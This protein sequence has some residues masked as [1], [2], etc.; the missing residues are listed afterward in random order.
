MFTIDLGP[1]AG[2]TWLVAREVAINVWMFVRKAGTVILAF[3]DSSVGRPDISGCHRTRVVSITELVLHDAQLS[4]E[5]TP[6]DRQALVDQ[7]LARRLLS[8]R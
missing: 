7:A 8:I 5:K 2:Q 6:T 1:T 4:A 3:F